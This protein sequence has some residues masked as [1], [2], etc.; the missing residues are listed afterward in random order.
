MADNSDFDTPELPFNDDEGGLVDKIKKLSWLQTAT[1]VL[2]G[3]IVLT[4]VVLTLYWLINTTIGRK[5][6]HVVSGLNIPRDT[7]SLSTIALGTPSDVANGN[8]HTISFWLYVHDPSV[9]AELD[10]HVFHLGASSGSLK[11]AV[12][13]CWFARDR[14]LLFMMFGEPPAD[15][16]GGPDGLRSYTGGTLG[17][18]QDYAADLMDRGAITPDAE[19]INACH[20]IA[21]PYVPARRWVNVTVTVD[22]TAS[23]GAYTAYVDGEFV[24]ESSCRTENIGLGSRWPGT[25]YVGGSAY[26]GEGGIGFPGL[27]TGFK[28]ANYVMSDKEV[29]ANYMASPIDSLMTKMGL[30]PYGVRSPVYRLA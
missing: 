13:T 27:L 4:I 25:A 6:I 3:A 2:A 22:E 17:D 30:P 15:Y 24:S 20:I 16:K 14:P 19:K 23:R 21:V 10:R 8:Q 12:M 18:F 5:K 11:G 26:Q 28:V 29:Y 1:W 9:H 7:N